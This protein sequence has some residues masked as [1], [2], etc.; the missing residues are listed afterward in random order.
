MSPRRALLANA[1]LQMALVA[2]IVVLANL[3]SARHFTR[4]DL[5]RDRLHSLDEASKALVQRLD[6]PL[7]VRAYLSRG[8]AAPYNNH[9]QLVRDKLEELQAYSGGRMKIT[10]IDPGDDPDLAAEPRTYGLTPLDLKVTEAN[11]A[12]LRRIWLGAVLLYGD[13]QEVLPALTDLSSLEYDL[14]SAIARLQQK[15]D[16]RPLLAWT[17]GNGEPDLV[18]PEG[19]LREMMEQLSRKFYLQPLALGG[20]GAIPEA[21]DALLVIG[22]QTPLSDRAVYQID[23]F[24]LRGG[25]AA[26]FVTH[27]RPDLRVLRPART[28]SGLEPLLGHYGVQV[29]RDIVI[30]RAQNGVMRFPARVGNRQTT[31]ELNYPLIPRATDLSRRSAL[32][33][34]LDAMLFPF[35]SSLQ[36]G[37]SLLHGVEAEVLARSSAS[38][39]SVQ[40]LKTI[41]PSALSVVLSSEKR[42]PFPLLVA[43]TG[44]L[45]SFFETRP[46]PPPD[47]DAP[48]MT[49]DDPEEPALLVEGA[50]TR[51]VVA[52]S[53]DMVAN[54]AAFMLNLAD[55][56]V[57]DEALIGIRSKIATLPAL[58][59]TTPREQ[60]AWKA[61]NLLVGPLAL[62]LFGLGRQLWF[63]RRARRARGAA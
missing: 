31:R 16:A 7:V 61:F 57:Q 27:T 42:G 46:V 54:N 51:L 44:P 60:L 8:L 48:P 34:G 18:K 40:D 45:R 14:A 47:P 25:A 43:L 38:A 28:S 49:D 20:P 22:P 50:P 29:N 4:L 53:A 59:P 3:Y 24:L 19:P 23:Q 17:T 1:W 9:A 2:L 35:T 15:A 41:D 58:E 10:V 33:S 55:W 39:G 63:R 32:T 21:V 36:V 30:D 6:R 5:T 12:E 13:R 11:R 56:L 62:L 52:A 26:V 37:E